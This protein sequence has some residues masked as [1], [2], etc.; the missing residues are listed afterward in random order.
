[1]AFSTL[2]DARARVRRMPRGLIFRYHRG[3]LL[4]DRRDNPAVAKLAD[5]FLRA[6]TEEGWGYGEQVASPNGLGLG[7]LTQRKLGDM[8]Y[9][10]LF[11]KR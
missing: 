1:M 4:L 9:E 5:F 3:Y 11:T 8:D 6:G 10:Y 2:K 7:F